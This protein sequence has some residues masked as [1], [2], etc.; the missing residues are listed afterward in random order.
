MDRIGIHFP[1]RQT[2]F[3]FY[4]FCKV[5]HQIPPFPQPFEVE[6][7]LVGKSPESGGGGLF[8]HFP[9]EDDCRKKIGSF[10]IELTLCGIG[11]FGVFKGTLP[12]IGHGEKRSDHQN[13]R[14][15]MTL[16]SGKDHFSDAGSNGQ[17]GH[18]P[19]GF[20][21]FSLFICGA[22]II[23]CHSAFFD[24]SGA[25]RI[26]KGKNFDWREFECCHLKNDS[27][28]AGP[29]DLRCGV[30]VRLFQFCFAVK[31]NAH[32]IPQTAAATAP[33]SGACLRDELHP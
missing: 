8:F 28:E 32:A 16:L 3:V 27:G 29:L 31:M 26:H 1:V 12:G 5:S 33:L 14:Q 9:P 23:Q 24:E 22:Q 7:V 2:I 20:R 11:F 25:R 17:L 6:I 18:C 13:L 15:Y 21:Q 30:V 10:R 19:T 4:N